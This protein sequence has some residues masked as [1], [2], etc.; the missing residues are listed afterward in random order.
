[1]NDET[2][3]AEMTDEQL[4]VAIHR[5][6]REALRR[7]GYLSARANQLERELRRRA[8]IV[9]EYGAP[10]RFSQA[11]PKRRWWWFW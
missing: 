9:S 6:R 8:G 11:Q 7:T 10:L 1:M 4:A 3:P 2:D 5:H